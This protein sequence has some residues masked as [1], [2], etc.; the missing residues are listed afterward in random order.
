MAYMRITARR[1][2][3]LISNTTIRDNSENTPHQKADCHATA[4]LPNTGDSIVCLDDC[5]VK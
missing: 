5:S 3:P 1:E 2:A 4:L